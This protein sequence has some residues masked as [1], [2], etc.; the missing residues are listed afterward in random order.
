[1]AAANYLFGPAAQHV[2]H[3]KIVVRVWLNNR[4]V[5]GCDHYQVFVVQVGLKILLHFCSML[6][7]VVNRLKYSLVKRFNPK[8]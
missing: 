1:M 8:L 6:K 4:A 2:D 3:L 7:S 5:A